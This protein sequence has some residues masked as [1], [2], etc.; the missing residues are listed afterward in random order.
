MPGRGDY[1]LCP[2]CWWEDDGAEP[3]DSDG[4]NGQALVEAQQTFLADQRPYGQR[5]GKVRAP[6][7]KEARDPDWMPLELTSELLERTEQSRADRRQRFEEER[8]QVAQEIADGPEGTLKD[9]NAAVS[10]L[11]MQVPPPSHREL[12]T[13]LGQIAGAHGITWS[14]A[15]L[16]L[17]SRWMSD[18]DYYRGHPMRAVWWLLRYP[19]PGDYR[20]RWNEVRNGEIQ[21]VQIGALP[22][23]D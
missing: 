23:A 21:V 14:R 4:P 15:H 16:E 22:R 1:D 11:R 19:G 13:Q 18:E 5:P 8:R 2:V 20:R 9:Y 7:K 3:W 10:S 17:L 12:K 6:R